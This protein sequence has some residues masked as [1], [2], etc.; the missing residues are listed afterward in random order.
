MP[1]RLAAR[2]FVPLPFNGGPPMVAV[3][4]GGHADA[5]IMDNY[6]SALRAIALTGESSEYYPGVKTFAELG[7]P[8]IKSGVNYIVA[9]PDGTPAPVLARLE[10][11]LE[12]ASKTARFRE[13]LASLKWGAVWRGQSETQQVVAT[14]AKAIKALVDEGLMAREK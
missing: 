2:D 13:V 11:A 5:L 14:E 6:N 4:L 10:A 3:V 9:A 7:Y 12:K 1:S 8:E